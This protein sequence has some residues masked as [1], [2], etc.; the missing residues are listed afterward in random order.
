MR[1]VGEDY[2]II[3]CPCCQSAVTLYPSHK[4]YAEKRAELLLEQQRDLFPEVDETGGDY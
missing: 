2:I 3:I 4:L 1:K